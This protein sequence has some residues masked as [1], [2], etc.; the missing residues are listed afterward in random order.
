[1]G[2]LKAKRYADGGKLDLMQEYRA[3]KL[4]EHRRMR[5]EEERDAMMAHIDE[6]TELTEL[7]EMGYTQEMALRGMANFLKNC[8][9]DKKLVTLIMNIRQAADDKLEQLM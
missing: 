1:M 6:R 8:A 7:D 2:I 3:I 9:K 4:M 5:L